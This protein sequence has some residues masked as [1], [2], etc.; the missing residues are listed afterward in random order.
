MLLRSD[1]PLQEINPSQILSLISKDAQAG[2]TLHWTD[3]VRSYYD[4]I[5]NWFAVV[6]R[7]LFEQRITAACSAAD[8]PDLQATQVYSPPLTSSSPSEKSVSLSASQ[9]MTMLS[10][11]AEPQLSREFALLI[12]TMYLSTRHRFTKAGER[13]MYDEIYQFV[14]RI[15]ALSLLESPLPK[16]ELV[17]CGALLAMY[18]YGHGDSLL[19]YR[20]LSDTV[21]AARVIQVKP[22]TQL[23][24]VQGLH[25]Q[26]SN[27]EEDQKSSLWW[28]LFVLDQFI[29]RDKAAE[30]LPFILDSPDPNTLLPPATRSPPSS[31]QPGPFDV[32]Y[33]CEQPAISRKRLPITVAVD[34]KQLEPFQLSAKVACLLHRAL[35]HEHSVR[36]RPWDLPPVTS[37]SSLDSEIRAATQK[38]LQDDVANWQVTLDSFAMA[39][40]HDWSTAMAALRFAAQISVDIS[41]KANVDVAK[42]MSQDM[43]ALKFVV[44]PA[45]PTCYLVV[46]TLNS[47]RKIFPEEWARCQE[48]MRAKYD[49]LKVF[50]HRW[51]IAGKT[52]SVFEEGGS[53]NTDAMLFAE[54]MMRQLQEVAGLDRNDFIE[55][56]PCNP[57]SPPDPIN[58]SGPM[59]ICG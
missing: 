44:A 36:S 35:R 27:L 47:V 45:A 56:E 28:S 49:S 21:G 37:F 24:G 50:A 19:A 15:V 40:S 58:G 29:H 2:E 32:R 7:A 55:A 17:Q 57:I 3:G 13:P 11:T 25:G 23:E 20:T 26:I 4:Y 8:S 22:G 42:T 1:N 48:D 39:V 46:K 12:V 10:S 16:I 41:C 30:G 43:T 5:H 14:K 51:G 33:L 38:L 31:T 52:L 18:E 59:E 6:Q 34:M 54:K 53:I 9:A